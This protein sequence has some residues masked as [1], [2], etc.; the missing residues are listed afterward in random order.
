MVT[1]GTEADAAAEAAMLLQLIWLASPALPV[2]SFS[3]S[4]GLEAAVEAGL[5]TNA[6]QAAQWLQ[7]Q[8]LLGQARADLAAVAAAFVAWRTGDGARI[9][10]LNA[11]VQATRESSEQRQQ[12]EQMGRSLTDWLRQRDPADA[13][14]DALAALKP[15]PTWPV[16]LA[17]AAERTGAPL[18][19]ALLA[20]AFGW[21]ENMVQA[22]V[23]AVPL[24][25]SAGQ[26]LLGELAARVPAAVDDAIARDDD[27]RFAFTP[28]L[29]IL[30]AQHETQ[31]SRLFRS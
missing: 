28:M 7:D 18:R 9:G 27:T 15:A 10:A 19:T 13:R 14:V 11:W 5:V 6:T 4:E 31:Y 23:K 20:L 30:S 26:Q 8:L 16:A 3:Y 17:L 24:G 22:A 29:A 21:A 1:T 25:Q 12:A 2:G